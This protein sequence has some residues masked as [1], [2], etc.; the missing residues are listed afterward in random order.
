MHGWRSQV[1]DRDP[2]TFREHVLG[3]VA[4]AGSVDPVLGAR[5]RDLAARRLGRPRDGMI[6][7]V[8]LLTSER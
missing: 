6:A 4:W 7:G 8:P 5:L 1:R 2:A 3:R